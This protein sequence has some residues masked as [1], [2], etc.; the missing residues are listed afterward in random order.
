MKDFKDLYKSKKKNNKIQISKEEKI[1]LAINC[2]IKGNI[3]EARKYIANNKIGA[4]EDNIR[5]FRQQIVSG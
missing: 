2:H 1:N 4:N 5:N 3:I